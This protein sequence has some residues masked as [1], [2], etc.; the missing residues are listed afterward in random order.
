MTLARQDVV[1]RMI[2]VIEGRP[3]Y[4]GTLNVCASWTISHRTIVRQGGLMHS[5]IY[6]VGLIV[7]IMVILSAL[8]LR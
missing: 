2:V 5:V 8:G 4:A 7:V 6:L 1:H 3:P